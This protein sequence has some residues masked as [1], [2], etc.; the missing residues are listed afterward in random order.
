MERY[1]RMKVLTIP[2]LLLGLAAVLL[3]ACASAPSVKGMI[4]STGADRF[5]STG[6]TIKVAGVAGGEK[7]NAIRSMIENEGF[8]EALVE[9]LRNSGIFS[10]VFTD[11][12][13]DYMIAAEIISQKLMEGFTTYLILYVEYR[14]NETASNKEIWKENILSQYDAHI[15]SIAD[16]AIKRARLANEGAVRGNLSQLLKKLSAILAKNSP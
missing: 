11:R 5:V 3:S 2:A 10:E 7:T 15:N 6:K 1:F 4:P 9:T 13:C 12:E 8:Q 16:T 14:L